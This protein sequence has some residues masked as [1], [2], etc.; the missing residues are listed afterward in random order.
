MDI[1]FDNTAERLEK[2]FVKVIDEY[3][4]P[5]DLR[6]LEMLLRINKIIVKKYQQ[7]N[8]IIKPLKV[9]LFNFIS[10]EK[11]LLQLIENRDRIAVFGAGR[12]AY[13]FLRF[14]KKNGLINKV[15]YAIVSDTAN[16][17]EQIE[18]VPIISLQE[19]LELNKNLELII[20]VNQQNMKEVVSLLEK[21]R[22]K[23][24]KVLNELYWEFRMLEDF[25]D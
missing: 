12:Y 22:Y 24:Y 4:S 20:A 11:K 5:E 7:L 6:I 16:T 13:V 3:I 23:K 14:L 9:L 1:L 2:D 25:G 8:Y 19:Y 15:E 18:G 21:K 10:Y 17:A